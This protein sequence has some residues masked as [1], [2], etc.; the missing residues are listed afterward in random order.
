MR[1]RN[2]GCKLRENIS[3]Q[4]QNAL[5]RRLFLENICQLKMNDSESPIGLEVTN[6]I[7]FRKWFNT[8]RILIISLA[9]S[10]LTWALWMHTKFTSLNNIWLLG[11]KSFRQVFLANQNFAS[12]SGCILTW[13]T[14]SNHRLSTASVQVKSQSRKLSRLNTQLDESTV[15][16]TLDF[17]LCSRWVLLQR[18]LISCSKKGGENFRYSSK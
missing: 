4:E 17:L 1:M 3:P 12:G 5:P 10:M 18:G 14:H 16:V 11:T 9:L 13:N 15:V 8:F 2:E 7:F 6:A